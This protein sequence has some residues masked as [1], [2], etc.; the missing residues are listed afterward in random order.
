VSTSLGFGGGRAWQIAAAAFEAGIYAAEHVAS[1]G[2]G[3][4]AVGWFKETDAKTRW[5][6]WILGSVDIFD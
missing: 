2:E 3:L 5:G 1:L 6:K 4:D